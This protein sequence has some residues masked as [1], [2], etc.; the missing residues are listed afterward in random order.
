MTGHEG[1]PSVSRKWNSKLGNSPVKI[2]I[3]AVAGI[4][5]RFNIKTYVA[6]PVLSF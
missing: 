5:T 2:G 3:R 1:K 4:I 6:H